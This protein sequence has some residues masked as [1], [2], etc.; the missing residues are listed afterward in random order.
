MTNANDSAAPTIPVSP[1][2]PALPSHVILL[3]DWG[4]Y[5]AGRVLAVDAE[6][7]SHLE[8]E[9]AKFRAATEREVSIAG[10]AA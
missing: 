4:S 6:R 2:K 7:Y 1:A 9:G 10:L 5:L 8:V 3:E